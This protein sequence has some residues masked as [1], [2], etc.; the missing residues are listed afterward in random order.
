MSVSGSP[1]TPPLKPYGEQSFYTASLFAAIGILLALRRRTRTGKG[2]HL[3]I[4]IQ[5]AVVSTLD[6]VL[7]RYFSEGVIPGRQGSLHWNR[8]FFIS[9]CQDGH[10]LLNTSQGWE[11]L[12]EWMASEGMAGDLREEDNLRMRFP[13]NWKMGEALEVLIRV[14]ITVFDWLHDKIKERRRA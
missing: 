5:E 9:P 7:V 14:A 10:I 11:T 13:S 12:V 8:S 1:S 2:E 6:H 4:S 3:D